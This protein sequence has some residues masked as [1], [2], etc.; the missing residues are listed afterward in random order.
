MTD[1]K[2]SKRIIGTSAERVG[3]TVTTPASWFTS[4]NTDDATTAKNAN[5][6]VGN[7][8]ETNNLL[9]GKTLTEVSFDI[10]V[11]SSY[12]GSNTASFKLW[13]SSGTE[14]HNFGTFNISTLGTSASKFTQNTAMGSGVTVSAGDYIGIENNNTDSDIKVKQNYNQTS[15]GSESTSIPYAKQSSWNGS[16]WASDI[17]ADVH[18]EAKYE[19][20]SPMATNIQTNTIFEESDTGK[21]YIW[22]GSAWVEV[23]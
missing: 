22:S 1:F 6:R 18:M 19:T 12:S 10:Y 17:N 16:A 21:H 4:P 9:V 15:G 2:A 14:R 3:V 11:Q 20:S 7:K 13:N 8:L 5:N 23:A